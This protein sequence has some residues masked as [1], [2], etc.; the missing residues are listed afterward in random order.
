MQERSEIL[1]Q[2]KAKFDKDLLDDLDNELSGNFNK[3]VVGLFKNPVEYDCQELNK[4]MKGIGANESALIEIL[5]SRSS[6]RIKEIVNK[7]PALFGDDLLEEIRSETSGVLKATLTA[8]IEN[9]RDDEAELNDDKLKKDLE[10]IYEVLEGEGD[11]KDLIDRFTIRSSDEIKYLDRSYYTNYG[12]ALNDALK[13]KFSG[14]ELKLMI[15][16]LSYHIDA[17]E[18]FTDK[19]IEAFKGL[20]TNDECLVR[21]F[22]T[23]NEI[24]L[25]DISEAYT[26]KT[27][28]SLKSKIRDECSGDY[29]DI[30]IELLS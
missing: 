29:K 6:E 16:I 3:I 8:L 19:L 2:Y 14:D 26:R 24:D 1:K 22:I 7:Y 20:G 13:K 12:I 21:V 18:Y 5:S 15:S 27:G 30:L 23:R 9:T 25:K 17:V 4:A 28:K 10:K 11:V